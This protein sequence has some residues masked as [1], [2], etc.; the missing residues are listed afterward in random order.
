MVRGWLSVEEVDGRASKLGVHVQR[1]VARQTSGVRYLSW[2]VLGVAAALRL[3]SGGVLGEA[4]ERWVAPDGS[5]GVLGRELWCKP[6]A[7]RRAGAAALARV[8]DRLSCGGLAL[9]LA[10][11]FVAA[12]FFAGASTGPVV[13]HG[14]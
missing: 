8:I 12:S 5:L 11:A 7:S 4:C 13:G 14:R 6:K 3:V 2:V 1:P 9:G 10:G